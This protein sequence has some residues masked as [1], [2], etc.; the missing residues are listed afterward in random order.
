MN[1]APVNTVPGTQTIAEGATRTFSPGN[2]N[3]IT[4][5]DVDA[6]VTDNMSIT[7]TG[8]NGT[9]TLGSITG[10]DFTVGDGT[11]DATMTFTGTIAE[12]NTALN[13]LIFTPPTDFPPGATGN[14]SLTIATGDG[15]LTTTSTV[16][17]TVNGVND[18]PVVTLPAGPLE[19][20]SVAT[21]PFT[22]ANVIT[23]TDVDSAAGAVRTTIAVTST[24]T[25]NAGTLTLG[26]TTGLTFTG[27]ANGTATMTFTGTQAATDAAVKT[28]VYTPVDILTVTVT[29]TTNDQGNSGAGTPVPLQGTD[30][31]IIDVIPPDLPFARSDSRTILEGSTTPLDINVLAR[32]LVNTGTQAILVGISPTVTPA[33][34][35]TVAIDFGPGQSAGA[36]NTNLFDDTVILHAAGRQH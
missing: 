36:G 22:G 4:I 12:V 23:V 15:T 25:G 35:G 33:G 7:L 21:L 13:G 26:S 11:A 29:V 34:G 16:A 27:G 28:L 30:S 18:A 31:V 10:L 19:V 1:D 32:V 14:A 24:G 3:A 6:I 20:A 5:A 9:V 17:I 8:N 2:S